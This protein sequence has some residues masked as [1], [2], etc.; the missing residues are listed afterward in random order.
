[1][2]EAILKTTDASAILC[3]ASI[4]AQVGDD[5]FDPAHWQAGAVSGGRGSAWRVQTPVGA[6]VLRHYRRGG[7]VAR[8]L[9]DRYWWQG[10][11]QTRP[12]VEFRLLQRLQS[13]QLPVPQPLAARFH[14]RG[15]FYRADL[16]TRLVANAATLA[17]RLAARRVDAE[18]MQR[19]GATL[20]QFHAAGAWHADLNAHNVLL[21][22]MPAHASLGGRDEP[23]TAVHLIDFDRGELRRRNG[24]W[25]EDNLA[26]LRRSLVKLGAAADGESEFDRRLWQPL[27]A[28]YSAARRQIDTDAAAA[29]GPT[30]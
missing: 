22:D 11:E 9:G 1:M 25:A 13:L 26:R 3:D 14:R 7:A 16:M 23:A 4:A 24:A 6:A 19:I 5:W 30:A 29:A 18:T 8:L 21:V 12:F 17:E 28:G 20:A 15:W 27:R 10:A 2:N